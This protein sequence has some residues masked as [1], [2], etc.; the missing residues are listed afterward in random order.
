MSL[1]TKNVNFDPP[2]GYL[3]LIF[4]NETLH[5]SYW[6]IDEWIW[7]LTLVI[8]P[9]WRK[10]IF[11]PNPL[12]MAPSS[13]PHEA[14]HS[15]PMLWMDGW[16]PPELADVFFGGGWG[17][18]WPSKCSFIPAMMNCHNIGVF[19]EPYT[20]STA[21]KIISACSGGCRPSIQRDSAEHNT[22]CGELGGHFRWQRPWSVMVVLV[23]VGRWRLMSDWPT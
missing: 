2:K 22:S 23:D 20:P 8:W 3:P 15:A 9:I 11:P 4:F 6:G 19:W 7:I 17:C 21:P 1:R 14:S 13:A 12:E 5:T 10:V 18:V 16:Q